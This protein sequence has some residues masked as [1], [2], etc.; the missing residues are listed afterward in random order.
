MTIIIIVPVG[1]QLESPS[2]VIPSGQAQANPRLAVLN[3][4]R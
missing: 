3:R 2:R 1:I 4:H